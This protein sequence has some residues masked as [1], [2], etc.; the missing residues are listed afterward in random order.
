L[1]GGSLLN[2]S[3]YHCLPLRFGIEDTIISDCYRFGAARRI[4]DNAR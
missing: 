3:G 4:C 2:D 1:S